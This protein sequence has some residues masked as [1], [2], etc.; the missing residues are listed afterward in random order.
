MPVTA[1]W[2]FYWR[3]PASQLTHRV[4]VLDA[5]GEKMSV[6]IT[7]GFGTR[8]FRLYW[9]MFRY[10]E[11]KSRLWA[12]THNFPSVLITD[13][14]RFFRNRSNLPKLRSHVTS[15]SVMTTDILSVCGLPR[16]CRFPLPTFQLKPPKVASL[17]RLHEP[18]SSVD[19]YR[20]IRY[21]EKNGDHET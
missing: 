17:F 15:L 7:E 21:V 4:A 9:P 20:E 10:S 12:P 3:S 6:K 13:C 8:I 19:G 14:F 2:K 16:V 1:Q 11:L 5:H 18:I